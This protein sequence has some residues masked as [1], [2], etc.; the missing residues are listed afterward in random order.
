MRRFL[1][2]VAVLVACLLSVTTA[3]AQGGTPAASPAACPDLS[4]DETADIA[5]RYLDVW[6]TKDLTELDAVA[7]PDVVHHWGQGVDTQGI[8]DLKASIE[9]FFTAFPDMVMT[10]DDTIVDGDMV[11]IRWTLTGT[12]TGPFFGMEPSGASAE[13]TGINIYRVECGQVV[14]SW[15]EAD[16]VGLRQQIHPQDVYA[17]PE[18]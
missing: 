3:S 15:S 14:E 7:H 18:S 1:W 2:V 17:T 5:L 4:R 13:W 6:N 10:F 11:V 8:D 12:Q 9:A 16:G